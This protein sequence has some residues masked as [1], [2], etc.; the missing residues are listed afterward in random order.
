MLR[1]KLLQKIPLPLLIA[2]QPAHLLLP[3][4]VHH[5]LDHSARLAVQVAERG[6]LGDNLAHVDLWCGCHDVRP[7]FHLVDLVEVD[8]DLLA[9]TG[10][11]EGPGGFVG[12]DGVREVSL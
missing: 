5:L 7:P 12:V 2:R 9:C 3:L 10:R 8:V 11:F 6:R 4:V 1:L